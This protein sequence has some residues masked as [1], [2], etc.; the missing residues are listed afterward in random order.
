MPSKRIFSLFFLLISVILNS[1]TYADISNEAM[2]DPLL[3]KRVEF[4][5]DIYTKYSSKEGLIHDAK[6]PSI[7][8]EKL[9]L[10]L[11]GKDNSITR[12]KIFYKTILLSIHKKLKDNKPLNDAE[13]RVFELFKTVDE[14]NKFFNAAHSK[15]IR[16]QLGQKENFYSGLRASGKYI[17]NMEKIFRDRGVPIEITRLPFVESSFNLNARSKVGAS[18]IWQFM[19]STG[20]NFLVINSSTDERNDPLKATAAAAE[21]LKQNYQTLGSWPLAITAYNHGRKGLMRATKRLGT[22]QIKDLIFLYRSRSFG[23][24]SS[25]C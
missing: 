5:I 1:T 10:R 21:L 8:Y 14:P 15:R 12:V 22:T 4:W 13:N 23:F 7:I 17:K 11:K 16:F 24:A 25:N 9:D 2:N 6:Y 20:K 18:G 19:R 3:K